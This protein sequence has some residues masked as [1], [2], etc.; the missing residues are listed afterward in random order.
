M[1][2]DDNVMLSCKVGEIE[3]A[4]AYQEKNKLLSEGCFHFCQL[5]NCGRACGELSA[6]LDL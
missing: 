1:M 2:G 3:D 4:A 6:Q 5:S